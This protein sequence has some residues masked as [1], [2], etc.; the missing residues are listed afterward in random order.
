M[1]DD[2]NYEVATQFVSSDISDMLNQNAHALSKAEPRALLKSLE[3]ED[4]AA[5]AKEHL[6][7]MAETYKT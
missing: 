1:V 7:S 2:I 3:K 4:T 6:Y 5:E